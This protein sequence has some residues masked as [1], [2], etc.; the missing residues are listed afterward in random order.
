M[1][2]PRGRPEGR[3][4]RHGAAQ[5]RTAVTSSRGEGT[6]GRAHQ[7]PGGE[8]MRSPFPGEGVGASAVP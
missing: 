8:R 1:S 7:F 6:G 4:Q 2:A 5:R 3:R